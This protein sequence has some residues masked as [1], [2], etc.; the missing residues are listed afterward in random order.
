MLTEG[1]PKVNEKMFEIQIHF[2]WWT[3]MTSCAFREFRAVAEHN[4]KV[5]MA[6]SDDFTSCS[7]LKRVGL[8]IYKLNVPI[9]ILKKY[10]PINPHP[11]LSK[12]CPQH[13]GSYWLRNQGR[14]FLKQRPSFPF[15][16]AGSCVLA[17]FRN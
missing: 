11:A 12:H 4:R 8:K 3:A 1:R 15:L 14:H 2:Y 7:L 17:S 5:H 16:Y 10:H 6:S 13:S 9:P